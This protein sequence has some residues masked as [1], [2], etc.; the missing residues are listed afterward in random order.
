MSKQQEETN[1][2]FDEQFDRRNITFALDETQKY[3]IKSFLQSEIDL[4]VAEERNR[5]VEELEIFANELPDE[6]Q[7]T[8]CGQLQRVSSFIKKDILSLITKDN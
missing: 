4:A 6:L 2:R 5:I 7:V 1:K 8:G 3:I